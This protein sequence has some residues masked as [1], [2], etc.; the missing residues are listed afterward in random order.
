MYDLKPR[1]GIWH[2]RG[3]VVISIF[4]FWLHGIYPCRGKDL[5]IQKLEER[6]WRG[7]VVFSFPSRLLASFSIWGF[8]D[9]YLEAQLS[10]RSKFLSFVRLERRAVMYF[11][12]HFCSSRKKAT[13]GSIQCPNNF[14]FQIPCLY[15]S[16]HVSQ[17]TAISISIFIFDQYL[18]TY[19][20]YAPHRRHWNAPAASPSHALPIHPITF[21]VFL[22]DE[23]RGRSLL[24]VCMFAC[25]L[26]F[27]TSS[28][29]LREGV[30]MWKRVVGWLQS[31]ISSRECSFSL[32]GL[33]FLFFWCNHKSRLSLIG[34]PIV[35]VKSG[36]LVCR[37]F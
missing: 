13:R 27:K 11:K 10:T 31:C 34:Y 1:T 28:L 2:Q 35:L 33:I 19:I 21:A 37:V 23:E 29:D 24:D 32:A 15:Q 36:F 16:A 4:D 18:L 22:Q 17:F 25:W 5:T 9:S 30:R 7:C 20:M 8:P 6:V 12:M 26:V 3:R 14:S